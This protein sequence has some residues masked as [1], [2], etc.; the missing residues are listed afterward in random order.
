MAFI[1]HVGKIGDRK[2]AIV[3]REVPQE[4]HMCLV[5]FTEILNMHIHDPLMQTIES[6]IGQNSENLADALNRT[7]TRDGKIILQILHNEGMLKKVQ[8]SQVVVTPNPQTAIR[9]DELNRILDEMQKGEEAVKRL[10]EIDA[11]SGLQDPTVV[12]KRLRGDKQPVK[13]SMPV[14]DRVDALRNLNVQGTL[15]DTQLAS[16]LLE[17][18]QR[19]EREANGLLAEARRLISEATALSPQLATHVAAPAVQH[20]EAPAP[21]VAVKRG[22]KPAKVA[23]AK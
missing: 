14:E 18:A 16:N 1:R 19:M 15:G 2:V 10:A 9:L 3:F 5:V 22:R 17:Q 13:S 21:V 7:Y 20:T 12:A 6:D 4:T 23:A 8:T 11:S